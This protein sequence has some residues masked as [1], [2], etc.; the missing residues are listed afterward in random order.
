MTARKQTAPEAAAEWVPVEDLVPWDRN[1]RD[2]AAAVPK[3]MAS[4]RRFGFGAPLLARRADKRVIAGHTRLAAA[5]ALGLTS[6]PVRFLD[7]DPA[8]ADMLA[9]QD[10]RVGE[11]STWKQDELAGIIRDLE[12]GGAN[13]ADLAWT[14]EEL[15]KLFDPGGDD[16]GDDDGV[17]DEAEWNP[18]TPTYQVVLTAT[19]EQHQKQLI[20][21]FLA[22][23]IECRAL[24]S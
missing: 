14:P 5:K 17:A 16:E 9:L 10:N 3:V 13:L 11:F 19:D 15:A 8:D 22:E 21:R 2:N 6:V 4:I 20:E 24:L 18:G 7:L 12:A 23:G 1:P